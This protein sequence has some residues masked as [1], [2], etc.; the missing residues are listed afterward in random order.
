MLLF[1]SKTYLEKDESILVHNGAGA[2]CEVTIRLALHLVA[3][4]YTPV[5]SAE[6]KVVVLK[7]GVPED[8][9]FDN[10][11]LGCVKEIQRITNSR[12]VDVVYNL[13]TDEELQ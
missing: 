7:N 5:T 10:I 3:D 12:G 2:V 4:V 9:I 1:T 6:E 8:H 11:D 13:L